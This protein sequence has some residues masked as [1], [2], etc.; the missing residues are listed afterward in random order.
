MINDGRFLQ[1]EFSFASN[2][3]KTTGL[4][5]IGFEPESDKFTSVWIDSRQTRMSLRQS[6]DKFDGE[7][8]VLFS[9]ELDGKEGRRSK[10][11]TRLED[12]G[13]KLI[14]RQY[15]VEANAPDRLVMELAMTRKTK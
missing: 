5:L 1:S 15:A 2:T 9:K 12:G 8:I 10:T 7:K 14:H 3:G 6:E 4:G 11:I 13:K